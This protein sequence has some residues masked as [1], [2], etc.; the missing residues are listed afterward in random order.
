MSSLHLSDVADRWGYTNTIVSIMVEPD[1]A[2][3]S[4]VIVIGPPE[5]VTVYHAVLPTLLIGQPPVVVSGSP[6]STVLPVVS[7]FNCASEPSGNAA[8]LLSLNEAAEA[9]DAT[10]AAAATTTSARNAE[11]SGDT[12]SSLSQVRAR[13]GAGLAR[14]R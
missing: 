3:S 11:R 10:I 1:V 4:V 2:G 14:G 12:F 5:P 8:A 7:T 6:A 9:G 13:H